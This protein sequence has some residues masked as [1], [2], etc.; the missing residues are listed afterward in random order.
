M[1]Y[2]R[3][4]A[5]PGSNELAFSVGQ[6]LKRCRSYFFAGAGAAGAAGFAAMGV[7]LIATASV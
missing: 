1:T 2:I 5:K 6:R 4:G 3:E 7:S